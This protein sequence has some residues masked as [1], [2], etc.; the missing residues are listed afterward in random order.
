M[1]RFL[2]IVLSLI[3]SLLILALLLG[4]WWG[5]G[6]FLSCEINP[7]HWHWSGKLFTVFYVFGSLNGFFE[8]LNESYNDLI[9]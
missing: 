8:V 2:A 9:K 5:I 3:I 4:I 1:N 7:L 6:Y